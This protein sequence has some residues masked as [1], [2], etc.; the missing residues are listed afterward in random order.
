MVPTYHGFEILETFVLITFYL[1]TKIFKLTV[2]NEYIKIS[3]ISI[4]TSKKRR[5]K[6]VTTLRTI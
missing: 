3:G 6:T 5:P 1:W 2:T 4:K